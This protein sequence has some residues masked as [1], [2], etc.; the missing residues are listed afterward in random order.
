MSIL[1]PVVYSL[2]V[3]KE[4]ARNTF[5]KFIDRLQY[6][7]SRIKDPT[8]AAEFKKRIN[9]LN[10]FIDEIDDITARLLAELQAR[11]EAEELAKLRETLT[12]SRRYIESLG[13]DPSTPIWL[14]MSDFNS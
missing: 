5:L 7:A 1:K 9:Y 13:G 10:S 14:K 12:I 6:E 4:T 8:A 2:F 11:P 3:K